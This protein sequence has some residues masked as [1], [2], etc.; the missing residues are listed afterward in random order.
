VL[1]G[2]TVR[3]PDGLALSSRNVR[4]GP[5]ARQQALVIVRALD[6]AEAAVR[7]GQGEGV[8]DRQAL[9]GRVRDIIA[10]AD[11]ASIDYAEL[12][13]PESLEPCPDRLAGP[14]LLALAVHFAP[15]PDGQGESVRLIDNRVLLPRGAS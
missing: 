14:S 1:G 5:V 6:A 9:L 2:P 15:D 7:E 4:L 12:R 11:L 8:G 10:T 13:D 3:E